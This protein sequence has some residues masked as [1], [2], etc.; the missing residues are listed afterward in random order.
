MPWT[1]TALLLLAG[2]ALLLHVTMADDDEAA[3]ASVD[4]RYAPPAIPA[5]HAA[6]ITIYHVNPSKYGA[7]PR[8]MNTA[9]ANGDLYFDLRSRGLPLECGPLR[10]TSFW[11]KL[12]CVNP[13]DNGQDPLAVTKLVLEVDTRFD[14]Y[15]DCNIDA[16]T[17]RYSCDCEDVPDN[18]TALT[19]ISKH[20]HGHAC[21]FS[22]GC[23]YNTL[24]QRCE[25]YGC[26]N[27]TD[28]TECT[29]GYH[30]CV[31]RAEVC[32]DPP[33]PKPVCDHTRVGRLNL[34]QV[35]WGRHTHHGSMSKVDF[36]HG[37]TLVKTFG[38]WYSTWAEGECTAAANGTAAVGGQCSWRVVEKIK[39]I[40]KKCSDATMD[41]AIIRG[42][43]TAPWG[44]R[45]FDTCSPGDRTNTTSPCFIE[46]FYNNVLGPKG[47]SQLMNHS[48]AGFG[49]PGIL[50]CAVEQ[51]SPWNVPR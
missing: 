37:N 4:Q 45:C 49:I 28:K 48:S 23:M 16:T 5:A 19:P 21:N 12:D 13:E 44:A 36:W 17:G 51:P 9:D 38:F 33:G 14:D 43:R 39:K 29:Q 31:W 3:P 41:A 47:S 25:P 50:S 22:N 6:N 8:N 24:D 15:A 34:T 2:A 35:Q 46:C 1:P 32:K 40:S 11:S 30:K 7:A 20:D 42:D 27:V 18:C 10:N 26:A